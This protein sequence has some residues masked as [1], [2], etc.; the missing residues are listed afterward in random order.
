MKL[1]KSPI[2]KNIRKVDTIVK[3]KCNKALNANY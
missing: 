2:E 3:N 1:S